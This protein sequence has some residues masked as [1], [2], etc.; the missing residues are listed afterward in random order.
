MVR[1]TLYFILL[2]ICS[3]GRTVL[4]AQQSKTDSLLTLLSKD[5]EDT[6]KLIHLYNLSD[7]FETTHNFTDGIKY[8]E[9]SITFADHLLITEKKESIKK[10]I[11]NYKAK[12]FHNIGIIYYEQGNYSEALK[13]NIAALNIRE[14]IGDK[15]STATSYNNIGNIYIYQGNYPE[16]LKNYFACLK[17]KE[18]IGDKKNIAYSLNNIGVVYQYQG[19]YPEALKNHYAALKIREGIDDKNG[20]ADSYN[21]IGMISEELGEVSKA[22][23]NYSLALKIREEINDQQGVAAAYINI[24]NVFTKQGN[25]PEGLKNYLAALKKE[26][27]IEDK[28]GMTASL[29]NIGFV[30]TKQKKYNEAQNYFLK[31]KN[32]ALDFGGKAHLKEVY[33]GLTQ[34][35]SARGNFKDA[36]EN[37]KNYILY[38][39]SLNNEET[40]KKTIQSQMTFDFEKKEAIAVAEHKKEMENQDAIAEEKSRKQKLVIAF[41]IA[42]LLLVLIFAGFIFRSLRLTR[43][44]KDIIEQ[45]KNIVEEQKA[46]VEQ[47]KNLVEEHQK[48]IIDSITYARRIQRALLPPENYI[49]K[50]MNRLRKF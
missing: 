1:N 36:Y 21:N 5:K 34:I 26:E 20:I 33:S 13:N 3:L 16:A 37:H 4:S 35:D 44:Q 12:S 11:L 19:N 46:E 25:Y 38:S 39:D 41:V 17:I 42:G 47:Q 22:L 8:G 24:G 10:T 29:L 48:E 6:T 23:K 40:R 2:I 30:F 27:A 45:Q 32:F 15:N 50:N 28:T 7:E 43:K 18:E 49:E 9:R 31:A 14:S